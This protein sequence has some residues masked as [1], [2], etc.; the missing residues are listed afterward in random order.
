MFAKHGDLT[1]NIVS[2]EKNLPLVEKQQNSEQ[3]EKRKNT[4]QLT[5]TPVT[6]CITLTWKNLQTFVEAKAKLF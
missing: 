2:S 4:L 3:K 5:L 6:I 1:S